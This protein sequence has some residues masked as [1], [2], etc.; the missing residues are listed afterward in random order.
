MCPTVPIYCAPATINHLSS[1]L[2]SSRLL[3]YLSRLPNPVTLSKQIPEPYSRAHANIDTYVYAAS[4]YPSQ[5]A[6]NT[7]DILRGY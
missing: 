1:F 5:T 4:I 3:L 2:N 6:A 7:T